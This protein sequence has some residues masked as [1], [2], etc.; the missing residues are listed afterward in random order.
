MGDWSYGAYLYGFPV[1]QVLSHYRLQEASFAG[2][3][4]VATVVTFGL[5]ALSW[6]WVEKQAL[7]WK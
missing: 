7:R 5:A 6:H 3:V 2:Y 4:V 1:Q